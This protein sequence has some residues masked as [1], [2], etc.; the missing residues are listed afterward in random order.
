[1][2]E[3]QLEPADGSATARRPF[4]AGRSHGDEELPV[5]A[6]VVAKGGPKL[7][8]SKEANGGTSISSNTGRMTAKGVTMAK[9][10]QTL[11][12]IL[13]RELGRIVIDET[14]IEGKV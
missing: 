5:Y 4:Q 3:T 7:T 11:T 13:A 10:T 8:L 9:L 12:Q 14:G 2:S 6:L 1:M